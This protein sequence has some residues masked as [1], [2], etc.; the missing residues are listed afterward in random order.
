MKRIKYEIAVERNRGTE[1][2][3]D[4]ERILFP[5]EK[6][7][8]DEFLDE[9]LAIAQEEAYNGKVAVDEVPEPA[10]SGDSVWDELDAAYQRGVDSV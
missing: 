1:Q 10:P 4:I 2:T 8:L 5:I 9:N 3:P 6:K 7:C